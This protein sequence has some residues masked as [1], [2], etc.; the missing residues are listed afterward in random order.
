MKVD[1][2]NNKILQTLMV[3]ARSKINKIAKKCGITP[4]AVLKRITRMKNQGLIRKPILIVNFMSFGFNIP[5]LIG[6]SLNKKVEDEVSEIIK[7]NILT[8]GINKTIGKYDLC[9]FVFGKNI[10][11][12]ENIQHLLKNQKDIGNV[13]IHIWNNYIS[14]QNF[15]F[16][17]VK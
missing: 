6:I 5:A 3:D 14:P 16:S 11:E 7:K 2:I 10:D 1:E 17:N 12:L 8:A 15:Q 13:D 9:A 4:S